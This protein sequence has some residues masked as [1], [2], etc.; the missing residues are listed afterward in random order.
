MILEA[1]FMIALLSPIFFLGKKTPN[2]K[3]KYL[4]FFVLYFVLDYCMTSLPFTFESLQISS[5]EMN[6]EGKILSY[7]GVLVFLI[8]PKEKKLQDIGLN[9]RVEEDAKKYFR[10]NL[11][12]TSGIVIIYGILIGGYSYS[13]ENALFQLTMPSIVEEIVYRGILLMLLNEVFQKNFKIGKTQFGMGVIIT[14]ILF[15]LLH[16][17]SLGESFEIQMNWFSFLLTGAIGFYLGL[18]RERSGSLL[19]PIL[20]HIIINLIPVIIGGIMQ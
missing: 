1:L 18:S 6:W 3:P 7:L 4:L 11:L 13:F 20:L 19:L 16:G 2:W 9:F 17:L 14:S 12:I 15:G 10:N 8:L 5:L